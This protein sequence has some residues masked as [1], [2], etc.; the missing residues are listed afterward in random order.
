[1]I[2]LR[3]PF[4]SIF[5]MLFFQILRKKKGLKKPEIYRGKHIYI[6]SLKWSLDDIEHGILRRFRYKYSFGFLPN[7][8][9]SATIRELAVEKVDYRIHFCSKL[10][11]KSCPHYC[12]LL[13]RK[14]RKTVRY[15]HSFFFRK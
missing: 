9:T 8:F 11:A 6:A 14:T 3:N 12:F 7:L 15:G 4:G 5:I 1:M 13:L 2:L 10:W